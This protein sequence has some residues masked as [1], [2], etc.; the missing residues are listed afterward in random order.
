MSCSG[1]AKTVA[2]PPT[3]TGKQALVVGGTAGIGRGI[4]V[5]LANKGCNVT[6]MGRSQERGAQVVE[7]MQKLTPEGKYSFMKT[8]AMLLATAEKTAQAWAA[9][10]KKLDYLALIA[11]I[12][13]MAGRNETKEGLSDKMAIHY[14]GRVAYVNTLLPLLRQSEDGRVLTVLSAGMHSPYTEYKDKPDL[15]T[16]FSLS[17]CANSTGMY[18]DIAMDS[19]SRENPNVTFTH[20]CP[21]FVDSNW[22]TEL[23]W[24]LRGPVRFLQLFGTSP[25][26]CATVMCKAFTDPDKKTGFHLLS[27][28]GEAA[29]PTKLHE[30]ARESVWEHTCSVLAR[31]LGEDHMNIGPASAANTA[32][33]EADNN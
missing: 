7:E 13:S 23:P 22:G 28:T 17:N 14:Y 9:E 3:L 32:E 29:K 2:E 33:K 21:G 12:G 31:V 27:H 4:A 15:K 26:K 30:Q 25:A 16:N 8:D 6:I 19:L 20:A 24:I 5:H 18:N 10:T 1:D 11:G